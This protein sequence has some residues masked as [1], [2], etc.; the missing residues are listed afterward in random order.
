MIQKLSS[1]F[2]SYTIEEDSDGWKISTL[3]NGDG[4]V[5]VFKQKCGG[6]YGLTNH[7]NSLTDVLLKEL[8]K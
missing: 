4:K 5:K 6:V 3:R 8:L 7:F 1:D 2:Y